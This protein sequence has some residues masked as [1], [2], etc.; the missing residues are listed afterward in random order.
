MAAARLDLSYARVTAPIAG[1][2]DRML[3]TEGNLVSGG[4]AGAATLLTTIV[5]VDPMY[6]YFDIDEGTYLNHMGNARPDASR[7]ENSALLVQVGLGKD[8]NFPFQGTLDFVGNQV[9][10]GTGTV[11]ARAVMPNPDGYLTP[12]MFARARLATGT[13]RQ[14]ILI[15]DQ[16]V[17][18]DQDRNY[19]LVV[20]AES[21]AQYRPIQLGPIRDGLRVVE[22][23]LNEGEQIVLKGLVRPGMPITPNV[24]PM[25]QS[26][27]A[28]DSS[29]AAADT[30]HSDSP[31]ADTRPGE[32]E[33]R[34]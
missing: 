9:D 19:V 26:T 20:D 27:G 13:E 1:R 7:P 32:E 10:R 28:A 11:R 5:S 23:G 6:V 30:E 25:Q 34:S 16:A 2:V 29:D 24:V 22:G 15:D 8:N 3:V 31:A 18:S 21:T 4:G 14:T 33:S 12:G 17:G